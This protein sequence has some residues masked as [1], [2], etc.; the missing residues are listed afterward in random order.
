MKQEFLL[1]ATD[2]MAFTEHLGGFSGDKAKKN[3]TCT[4]INFSINLCK[5]IALEFSEIHR[6]VNVALPLLVAVITL[7]LIGIQWTPPACKCQYK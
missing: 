5:C 6:N 1:K 7:F 2:L 4:C 3:F